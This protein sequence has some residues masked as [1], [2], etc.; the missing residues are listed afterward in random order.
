MHDKSDCGAGSALC[1]SEL[2]TT[3][4]VRQ[5]HSVYAVSV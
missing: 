1:G 5:W 4:K 3:A 2:T